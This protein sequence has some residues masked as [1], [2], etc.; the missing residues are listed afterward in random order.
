MIIL[1]RV[2]IDLFMK[3]KKSTFGVLYGEVWMCADLWSIGWPVDLEFKY[4]LEKLRGFLLFSDVC[5]WSHFCL[6]LP[7]GGNNFCPNVQCPG[8]SFTYLYPSCSFKLHDVFFWGGLN[9]KPAA[10]ELIN[11][12]INCE[13]RKSFST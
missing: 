11:G 2:R 10:Q 4:P 1:N 6:K 5:I 13:E 3:K 9:L 8:Y 7:L 12:L